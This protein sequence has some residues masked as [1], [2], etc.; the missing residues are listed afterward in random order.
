[1]WSR[2]GRD[3]SFYEKHDEI[4][5]LPVGVYTLEYG[6]FGTMFLRLKR[7]EYEFPYKLYGADGFPERVIQTF[8]SDRPGNLGVL[9]CGLKGTGKTVQAEQICN[10][11]NLP[12]ILV[13][14]EY[15]KGHDLIHFLSMVNQDVV[16][17][18]DEYEKIFGKSDVLLSI[19]DGAQNTTARRLF[20]LT[21][22]TMNV[23]DA[24]I[25]RPSRIY[26]LKKFNNL[27][28]SV[29][30]EVVDDMLTAVEHRNDVIQYISMLDIA[31]IDIIK[32]IVSEV[33][34]FN[35]SPEKFKDILNVTFNVRTRWKVVDAKTRKVIVQHGVS[36]MIDP[37][38]T[39][40]DLNMRDYNEYG[41]RFKDLG[42]IISANKKT[43]RITVEHQRKKVTYI[44]TESKTPPYVKDFKKSSGGSETKTTTKTGGEKK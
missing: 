24:M 9:L 32:T 33:N 16:V 36:D 40:Y 11:S 3:Y 5:T 22:N 1:M 10:L 27:S 13:T 12:V 43:N 35:E 29:I 15:N 17:M 8:N 19:M 26:Y 4:K 30:A 2:S 14:Q 20:V 25:D 37:F 44:V 6:A 21:A 28:S 34:R 38:R 39:H 31:T 23:S 41:D 7:K 18:I 42:Y